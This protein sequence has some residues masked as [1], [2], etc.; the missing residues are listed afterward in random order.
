MYFL[1][2]SILG[3]LQIAPNKADMDGLN[4]SKFAYFFQQHNRQVIIYCKLHSTDVLYDNDMLPKYTT[5]PIF[6]KTASN[7]HINPLSTK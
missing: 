4:K 3:I 5:M 7:V 1:A 2:Q 6:S